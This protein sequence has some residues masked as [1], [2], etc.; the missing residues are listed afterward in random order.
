LLLGVELGH[1]LRLQRALPA[2]LEL[3]PRLA[4]SLALSLAAAPVLLVVV[5][6][7]AERSPGGIGAAAARRRLDKVVCG[8]RHGALVQDAARAAEEEVRREALRAA[9]FEPSLEGRRRRRQTA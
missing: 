7:V 4:L 1:P 8:E 6:V 3:R 9:A 5:V 2:A